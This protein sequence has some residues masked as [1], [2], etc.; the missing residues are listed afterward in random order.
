MSLD[1]VSRSFSAFTRSSTCL[2]CCKT[3][4]AFSWSCQKFGSLTFSSNVASCLRAEPASKKA[5]HELNTFLKLGVAL[6]Q[7]FNMFGHEGILTAK[8]GMEHSKLKALLVV[9][10]CGRFLAAAIKPF[11]PFRRI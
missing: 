4:C 11:G 5:P 2:R 7:V 3:A 9:A 10:L 8:G 1:L 6:L